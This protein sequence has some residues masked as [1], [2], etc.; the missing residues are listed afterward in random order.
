MD[1]INFP[2]PQDKYYLALRFMEVAELNKSNPKF[3]FMSAYKYFPSLV[4]YVFRE[5]VSGEKID[6]INRDFNEIHNMFSIG[7]YDFTGMKLPIGH[8]SL[9]EYLAYEG[10]YSINEVRLIMVYTMGKLIEEAQKN[11]F[12]FILRLGY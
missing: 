8:N 6:R 4:S 5:H 10:C 12:M 1:F 9:F 11:Y 2:L 7:N 3:K